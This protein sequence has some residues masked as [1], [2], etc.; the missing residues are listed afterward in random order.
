MADLWN[1]DRSATVRRNTNGALIEI[2]PRSAETE[3][4][5]RRLTSAK[6]VTRPWTPVNS[7]QN[8]GQ[9][10]QTARLWP[11]QVILQERQRVVVAADYVDFTD[12]LNSAVPR[13]RTLQ[14]DYAQF[15]K[16]FQKLP[17]AP[18]C[19][20]TLCRIPGK[21][22]V[23]REYFNFTASRKLIRN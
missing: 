18:L 21:E 22:R 6:Q 19:S 15:R 9:S 3:L 17:V 2:G 16:T 1:G 8:L 7:C 12:K 10:Q 11:L 20:R 23:M 5:I 13:R 4:D 14:P